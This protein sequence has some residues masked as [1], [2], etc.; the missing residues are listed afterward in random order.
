MLL[1]LH[2]AIVISHRLT[3]TYAGTSV[4]IVVNYS[5]T[6]P[7]RIGGPRVTGTFTDFGQLSAR[8]VKQLVE[9][10]R[11]R[12]EL[13]FGHAAGGIVD[14]PGRVV[15]RRAAESSRERQILGILVR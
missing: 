11:R 14:N 2:V 4:A 5:A 15:T 10:R 8:V 7:G 3:R 1:L 9:Y 12:A 6:V 13:F